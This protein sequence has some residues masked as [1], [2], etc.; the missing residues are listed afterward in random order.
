[1]DEFEYKED[2]DDDKKREGD[3]SSADTAVAHVAVCFP[4][5]LKG[6]DVALTDDLLNHHT[7]LFLYNC[8]KSQENHSNF[9]EHK[10][11]RQ[12]TETYLLLACGG[13]SHFKTL[14]RDH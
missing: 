4:E 9:I 2:D 1:M 7:A 14:F 13:F 5:V 8:K 12:Y 3:Q 10:K 11:K 6:E